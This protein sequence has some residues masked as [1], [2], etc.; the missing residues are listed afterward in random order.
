[1]LDDGEEEIIEYVIVSFKVN[2]VINLYFF[3][4]IVVGVFDIKI[5]YCFG[6]LNGGFYELFGL[7]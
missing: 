7:D 6:M 3:E 5:G 4:N 2:W 1:M